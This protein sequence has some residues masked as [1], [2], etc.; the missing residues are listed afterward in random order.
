M[1]PAFPIQAVSLTKYLWLKR[2]GSFLIEFQLS[3]EGITLEKN[4]FAASKETDDSDKHQWKK[5]L[6]EKLVGTLKWSY[7]AVT[8]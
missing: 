6:D 5:P 7:Q 4:Y 3:L 2:S 1:S 8:T